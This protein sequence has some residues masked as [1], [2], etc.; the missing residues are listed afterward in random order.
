MGRLIQSMCVCAGGEKIE[1]IIMIQ[2][3]L[4]ICTSKEHRALF[5]S[6]NNIYPDSNISHMCAVCASS[7]E[8]SNRL[9]Y[10]A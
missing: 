7:T 2:E 10:K 4:M 3:G 1:R 9:K 8:F 6:T 5:S